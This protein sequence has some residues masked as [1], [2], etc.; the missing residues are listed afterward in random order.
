MCSLK[1]HIIAIII[2]RCSQKWEPWNLGLSLKKNYDI[3]SQDLDYSFR[4]DRMMM[5]LMICWTQVPPIS[6]QVIPA[7]FSFPVNR[8]LQVI[9]QFP[10]RELF[11]FSADQK[12]DQRRPYEIV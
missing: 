8:R 11:H 12:L 2:I 4:D 1:I 9:Q 5:I 10:L 6:S 3:K 7:P